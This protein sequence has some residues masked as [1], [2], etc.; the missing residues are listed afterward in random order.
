MLQYVVAVNDNL[1]KW[2]EAN[3][4]ERMGGKKEVK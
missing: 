3:K 1:W 2:N 4:A